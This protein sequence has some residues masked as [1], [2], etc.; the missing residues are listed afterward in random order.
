MY[1]KNLTEDFR[2]R[3]SKTDMEFLRKL[4]E[5]RNQSVSSIVRSILSEYRRS[6]KTLELLSETLKLA[7]S[8]EGVAM[9][10]GDTKTE[11][12]NLV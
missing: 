6:V 9:S 7:K 2:L 3:L 10:N 1:D 12:D 11:F 5:E 4:S 8:K